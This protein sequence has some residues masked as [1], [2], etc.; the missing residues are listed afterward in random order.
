MREAHEAGIPVLVRIDGDSIYPG[1]FRSTNHSNCDL[2]S[3]RNEEF[4]Y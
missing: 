2:T 4:R 1:I 3:I